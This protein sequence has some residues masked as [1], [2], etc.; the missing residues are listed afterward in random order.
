M[1][2][3]A[4]RPDRHQLKDVTMFGFVRAQLRY[5]YGR[6]IALVGALL[7]A[8]TSF[9]VLTGTATTQRLE[10]T[11]T[12]N[13]SA[14]G[15]YDILVR[16]AGSTSALEAR[17]GLVSS[18]ALASL[19]GGISLAQW[20]EIQGVP[21]VDVAA[22]VAVV[23]YTMRT[24][25]LPIDAS[26]AL[27]PLLPT[28]VL[29]ISTT[30]VSERGLT[31]VP[32]EEPL[33]A[34]GT[35]VYVSDKTLRMSSAAGNPVPVEVD[36]NG[37]ERK[38][39]ETP[40][41][42]DDP[43][44]GSVLPTA[45]L[46]CGST[47]PD[48]TYNA[49]SAVN[50]QAS[51]TATPVAKLSV[52]WSF[53]YLIQAVDP[54]QEAKLVG[55]DHAVSEGSYFTPDQGPVAR[56]GTVGELLGGGPGLDP[57][58]NTTVTEIPVLLANRTPID[59]QLRVTVSR[60]PAEAAVRVAA[61]ENARELAFTL[62]HLPG[63]EVSTTTFDAQQAYA[64]LLASLSGR[65]ATNQSNPSLTQ[66]LTGLPV[67]YD[68]RGSELVAKALPAGS[69]PL[70]PA[71]DNALTISAGDLGKTGDLVDTPVRPMAVHTAQFPKNPISGQAYTAP[72]LTVVG[73]FDPTRLEGTRSGLGAVPMET[74]FP[75]QATGADEA[76]RSALN[77]QTLLPN[78]N[79]RGL[80]SVPP[81]MITTI[82]ALSV[83]Q[84][85][86]RYDRLTPE[87]GVNPSAPISVVRVKLS[88]ALGMDDLSRER[89]R[90]V[91]ERIH[92]LTDLDVDV[93]MGSS[94]SPVTVA[95]PAGTFG[96]PALDLAQLW[97]RKGVAAVIVAAIDRK[98]LILFGLVLGVCALFV[99]GATNATVRSRRTELAV[100]ACL[101]WPRRRLFG[102]ILAEIGALG[103]VAGLAG[104]GLALPVGRLLEVDVGIAHAALAVP[105]AVLLALLAALW[106]AIR[107]S[108]SHPGAAV[109]PAVSGPKRAARL[110]GIGR[111]SLANLRR[112]PGRAVLGATALGVGV[113]SLV[114]LAAISAA[115]DG[116]V[117]GT[118]LGDA[119]SVQVRTTD[120]VAAAI[121]V[122]LGAF[123]VADVLYI[124]IRERSG[125]YALL[126][127]TGWED[128]ALF[129][130]LLT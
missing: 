57:S 74:Y 126:H 92:D 50:P 32:T 87:G 56:T 35:Y 106:P 72:K 63:T 20:Q 42:V 67:T 13:A 79:V 14:R 86:A 39:C 45:A 9:A 97:S 46:V 73:E 6:A 101:G 28:Q 62:P 81:S 118:L 94:P 112:V 85:P 110:G 60:L 15:A 38:I 89:V 102:L 23:G 114:G 116:A 122:L 21:G 103:L 83:L 100:L 37:A 58:S 68:D 75:A 93:T 36:A 34:A 54:V 44:T 66:F 7:V 19:A 111:L 90:L 29:R 11:G 121:A 4:A 22:P 69:N 31:K 41:F 5:R 25:Y 2:T 43:S 108:R 17:D 82:S 125:E 64:S 124:N 59:E 117:T 30:Q 127:A 107:S 95:N 115:F 1:Q 80:L 52:S 47:N 113:A 76:S 128:S 10:V 3:P 78:G 98:S 53:P 120:Y 61:G 99:A 96:R 84:D 65:D 18:T 91:A 51:G 26:T 55:L 24:L 48:N 12:V 88:G 109:A 77:G 129:R 16:P 71:N 27:D 119:V 104:A 130:L 8:V 49:P 70:R 40:D 123:T 33:F 105:A